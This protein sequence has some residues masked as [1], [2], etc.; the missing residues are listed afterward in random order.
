MNP[1]C[2]LLKLPSTS[3]TTPRDCKLTQ[4]MMEVYCNKQQ[5]LLLYYYVIIVFTSL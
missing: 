4:L 2:I 1:T 5:P 3:V